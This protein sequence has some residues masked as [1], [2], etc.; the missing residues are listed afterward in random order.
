M[1]KRDRNGP[2]VYFLFRCYSEPQPA[3]EN[4]PV[5]DLDD[6]RGELLPGPQRLRGGAL[7][8]EEGLADDPSISWLLRMLCGLEAWRLF[9][10]PQMM[11]WRKHASNIDDARMS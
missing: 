8:N 5:T 4:T 10:T 2:C 6:P 11:R 1:T 3:C 9:L 7:I